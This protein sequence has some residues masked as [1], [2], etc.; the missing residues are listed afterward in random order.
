MTLVH[1]VTKPFSVLTSQNLLTV[2]RTWPFPRPTTHASGRDKTGW[3]YSLEFGIGV[4][5]FE[6]FLVLLGQTRK[7]ILLCEC[8]HVIKKRVSYVKRPASTE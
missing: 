5:A 6:G 2:L 4:L 8:K 1:F 3:W 7:T